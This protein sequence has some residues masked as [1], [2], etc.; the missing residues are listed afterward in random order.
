[1]LIRLPPEE[2]RQAAQVDGYSAAA[3]AFWRSNPGKSV[4]DLVTFTQASHR[5]VSGAFSPRLWP[6]LAVIT[7]VRG[8]RH[9]LTATETNSSVHCESD[10]GL[11]DLQLVGGLEL[12][13]HTC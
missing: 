2:L 8:G 5:P 6:G 3:V 7:D 12:L 11:E 1:M 13:S 10:D 9:D 4:D